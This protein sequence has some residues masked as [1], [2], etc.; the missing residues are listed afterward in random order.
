MTR[1]W[2]PED[3]PKW[4]GTKVFSKSILKK[5]SMTELRSNRILKRMLEYLL[6][7][8]TGVML[9]VRTLC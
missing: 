7:V 4:L 3:V 9:E 5:Y 2:E 8:G 1:D 6:V